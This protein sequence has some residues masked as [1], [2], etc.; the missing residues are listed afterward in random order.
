NGI[1]WAGGG[2][3]LPNGAAAG[4]VLVSDASGNA[5]WQTLA[6]GTGSGSGRALGGNTAVDPTATFVGTT[7]NSTVAFRTNNVERMRIDGATGNV[8]IGTPTSATGFALSVT[9]SAMFTKVKVHHD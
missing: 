3:I 5:N 8:S 9:G 2:L 1:V 4:K 7:D 6:A